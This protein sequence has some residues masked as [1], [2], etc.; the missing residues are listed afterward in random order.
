MALARGSF[1]GAW[2]ILA[3]LVA[4]RERAAQVKAPTMLARWQSLPASTW[5]MA[6]AH[7]GVGVF[8]I[9]VAGVKTLEV[10]VDAA[11][12]P[13]QSLSVSGYRMTLTDMGEFNGPNYRGVR[14]HIQV[15]PESGRAFDLHPEKRF[16]PVTQ[17]VMTEAA[18]D[19]GLTRDVY[20]SLGEQLPD[21]RWTVKA[22]IKPFVDWIWAGCFLMALGGF[23]T[24]ADRRYRARTAQDKAASQWPVGASAPT[25]R[26]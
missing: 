18:I 17:S 16:Y 23:M 7:A 22:W 21:G 24:L 9:G 4:L 20:V 11:L 14:A 8:C 19:S 13:G 5:A 15:Q 25:T 10:E 3:S 2:L 6:V 12:G 26:P 1:L